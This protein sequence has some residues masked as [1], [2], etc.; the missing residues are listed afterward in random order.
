MID[1]EEP[2]HSV[3]RLHYSKQTKI[4]KLGLE[5]GHYILSFVMT[6]VISL[7]FLGLSYSTEK[8]S[9]KRLDRIQELWESGEH[10]SATLFAIGSSLAA[11]IIPTCLVVFVEPSAIGS[12]MTD[13]I[14]FLNGASALQG[15][16]LRVIVVKYLGIIGLVTAGLFSG[17]DGPM[18]QIGAGIAMILVR[19]ATNWVP[20]RKLIYGETLDLGLVDDKS[21]VATKL[22]ANVGSDKVFGD[23]E[24]GD[25]D[26]N[27][28]R[29]RKR[30]GDSLLGFLRNTNYRLFATIGAAVALSVIFHAPIGGVL[31]AVEEASSF[32]ELA[33]LIKLIFATTI[34]FLIVAYTQFSIS[35][36]LSTNNIYLDSMDSALF[37]I[38]T[39]CEFKLRIPM[40]L[41]YAAIGIF[42][43]LF[44][45]FLNLVLSHI[46]KIRQKYLIEVESL[47]EKKGTKSGIISSP[48]KNKLNSF[49]RIFEV[50]L[51][52]IITAI[53]VTWIPT[54]E[55][56]ETCSSYT[57]PLGHISSVRPECDFKAV[58]LTCANLE[59]CK[60][61]LLSD[62]I[63]YPSETA[64][65][66]N[67]FVE[68]V[69]V[70]FCATVGQNN[71]TSFSE[72]A[73]V[74]VVSRSVSSVETPLRRRVFLTAAEST[75]ETTGTNR[76]LTNSN[77]TT[78]DFAF[79]FD[80]EVLE[81][82]ENIVEN[83]EGKCYYQMRSLFWSPPERQLKLLLLRGV[84]DI[85]DVK[86]LVIFLIIYLLM[87]CLTYYIALP[88]DLVV[89]NLIIGA[90][91]GRLVGISINT[92]NPGFV[93]PG[94]TA[95]I[96]MTSLWSGTSGLVLTVIAVALELTGDFSFLPALIVASFTSAWVSKIIGPSLYHVEMENN[97]APYLPE[98]PANLLRTTTTDKIMSRH[99]I[100]LETRE[101]VARLK[102]ILESASHTGFPIVEKVR[103]SEND[104]NQHSTTGSVEHQ[105]GQSTSNI[106]IKYRPIGFV[107][108][109]RLEELLK[110]ADEREFPDN[111]LLD[112][113]AVS[114]SNP[115]TVRND[116]TA[117]KV[118]TLF[119][120]LGLKRVFVVDDDG[121]LVGV[122]V[123]HDLIRPILEKETKEEEE[124][125]RERQSD[126]S[127]LKELARLITQ[128]AKKAVFVD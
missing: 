38:K 96:G 70:E 14:A 91:A 12:G 88:T 94:A 126:P 79:K 2:D 60:N 100:V 4:V 39:N 24:D 82:G 95:L 65:E 105:Y 19:G 13:V 118:F 11:V 45:Q 16:S 114:A 122:V 71:E 9:E 40:I 72:R 75:L 98:E 42:A 64:L 119:R 86:S 15:I 78:E 90:I 111:H 69:Y 62:G 23:T 50:C 28:Q 81:I 74:T 3:L 112:I 47:R 76:T 55:S 113:E 89:P 34:G 46:Q 21:D 99:I 36:H 110:E 93:D 83:T 53:V 32:F 8:L 124:E 128:R 125:E 109:N 37:P 58:A 1:F 10:G 30:L 92:I 59:V 123:R 67:N 27:T 33:L 115:L 56:L 7:L 6:I 97:G 26:G 63:C 127:D 54:A 121:F 17:I 35:Q 43:G 84:Y 102:T 41:S 87:S 106:H 22:K 73:T 51:I 85:W 80:P 52:A 68:E 57:I 107:L 18:C 31:F 117:S 49:L 66:F 29:V 20:F 101:T 25:A 103:V 104:H 48:V 61:L 77:I 116:A 5:A 108:W 120:Q 44:G